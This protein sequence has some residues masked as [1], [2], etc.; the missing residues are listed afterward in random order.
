MHVI[1]GYLIANFQV[2]IIN[3]DKNG[4][5][6]C[7]NANRFHLLQSFSLKNWDPR[8]IAVSGVFKSFRGY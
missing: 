7:Y 3:D 6:N 2:V 1:L 8:E 5:T 4:V